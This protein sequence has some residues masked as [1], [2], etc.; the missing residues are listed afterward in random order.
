MLKVYKRV[1]SV[2]EILN[3]YNATKARF[4]FLNYL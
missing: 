3:K 1:L 4:G 2:T